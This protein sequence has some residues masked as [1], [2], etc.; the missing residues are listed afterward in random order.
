M[1]SLDGFLSTKDL[2]FSRKV[3]LVQLH[4]LPL[5]GMTEGIG[6]QVDNKIGNVMALDVD[7]DGVGWGQFLIIKLTLILPSH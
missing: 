2:T 1:N 6:V 5:S 3:L 4:N 7:E